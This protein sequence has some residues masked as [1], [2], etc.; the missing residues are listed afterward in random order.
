MTIDEI[1]DFPTVACFRGGL[2]GW[3]SNVS[4]RCPLPPE[5]VYKRPVHSQ[6][7]RK[8]IVCQLGASHHVTL[9][10]KLNLFTS[11][12]GSQQSSRD[13]GIIPLSLRLFSTLHNFSARRVARHCKCDNDIGHNTQ[14]LQKGS[15]SRSMCISAVATYTTDTCSHST[16]ADFGYWVPCIKICA[17]WNPL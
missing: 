10:P 8:T 13:N 3:I 11:S 9:Q 1:I 15:F 2:F 7:L 14:P 6:E 4:Q 12:S 16:C 5:F 17:G